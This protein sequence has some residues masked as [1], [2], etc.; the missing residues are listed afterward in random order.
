MHHNEPP[1]RKLL[2]GFFDLVFAVRLA[3]KPNAL[4]FSAGSAQTFAKR[5]STRRSRVHLIRG[6]LQ[7]L[8]VLVGLELDVITSGLEVEMV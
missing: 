8:L 3:A 2:A 5:N 4:R 7:L 1:S 6:Y